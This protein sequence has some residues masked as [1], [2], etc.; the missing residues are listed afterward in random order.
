MAF[1]NVGD[2]LMADF[3]SVEAGGFSREGLTA[4]LRCSIGRRGAS[5]RRLGLP[6]V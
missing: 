4:R 5:Y 3:V 6:P 1:Q 2:G